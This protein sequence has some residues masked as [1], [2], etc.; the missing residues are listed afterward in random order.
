MESLYSS[1]GAYS[2]W[3]WLEAWRAVTSVDY[4]WQ[5]FW[6]ALWSCLREGAGTIYPKASAG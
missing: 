2:A 5:F 3:D 1:S 6:R 4:R